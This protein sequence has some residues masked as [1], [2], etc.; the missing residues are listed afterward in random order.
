MYLRQ[1]SLFLVA[2]IVTAMPALASGISGTYVGQGSNAAFLIQVVQTEDGRLTGR[3]EQVVMQTSGKLDNMNADL[4]GATDGQ[5][6]ALTIKPSEFLGGSFAVSGT[7]AGQML[8]LTGG[9]NGSSLNLNLTKSDESGFRQQVAALMIQGQQVGEANAREEAEKRQKKAEADQLGKLQ[10]LTKNMADFVSKMDAELTKF[11]PGEQRYRTIT[12]HM[13]SALAREKSI[14]GNGQAA[15]AR[16]QISVS[17]NQDAVAVNQLHIAV[18]SD[19]QSFNIKVNEITKESQNTDKICQGSAKISPITDTDQSG[20]NFYCANY[21][22]ALGKFQNRV[23]A[24]R[25]A[26][27]QVE[28]VWATERHNQDII[29][30]ASEAA[31]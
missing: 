19:E 8:H 11:G 29:V 22:D 31:Q 21:Y 25:A 13:K 28:T 18:Q 12:E 17:I 14:Y 1:I 2:M 24:L 7:L 6:V 4:T 9:G 3:Y 27:A 5:T 16:S 26:F 20:K 15:V 23:L 30:Q 10:N